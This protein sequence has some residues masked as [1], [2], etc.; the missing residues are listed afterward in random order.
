M[1]F[2]NQLPLTS[3]GF[4]FSTY[5]TNL[6]LWSDYQLEYKLTAGKTSMLQA[7]PKHSKHLSIK[8]HL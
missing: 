1:F 7:H 3:M 4:D 8:I 2:N 6:N 5:K